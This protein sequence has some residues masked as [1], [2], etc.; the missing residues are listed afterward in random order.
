M[1]NE[2]I[3]RRL[4]RPLERHPGELTLIFPPFAWFGSCRC[5]L[6][7]RRR[8]A[9][10]PPSHPRHHAKAGG[11][12]GESGGE[13][14]CCGIGCGEEALTSCYGVEVVA[15]DLPPVIDAD[16]NGEVRSA[17]HIDSYVNAID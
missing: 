7:R 6:Y 11:E 5:Q 9:F 2:F 13:R 17:G 12:E 15:D 3:Q 16:R 1:Q 14:N 8:L 10:P 4:H